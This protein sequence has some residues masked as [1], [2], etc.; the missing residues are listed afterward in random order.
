MSL[1]GD[2]SGVRQSE[3]ANRVRRAAE[4]ERR[5][6][7]GDHGRDQLGSR[8]AAV[9]SD[10]LRGCCCSCCEVERACCAVAHRQPITA[11]SRQMPYMEPQ[12][13]SAF[14]VT[15]HSPA[16]QQIRAV[17]GIV[18]AH[19][20][21]IERHIHSPRWRR[22]VCVFI[23]APPSDTSTESHQ[24][25]RSLQHRTPQPNSLPHPLHPWLLLASP[26]PRILPQLHPPL[27]APL[28]NPLDSPTAHSIRL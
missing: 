5:R 18:T 24:N 7:L 14:D 9:V 11:R 27:S 22:Y 23:S 6:R 26:R 25:P 2:A 15:A 17:A 1:L 12:T 19:L 16:Q 3:L 4:V 13:L 10:E 8:A 21:S 20:I 28:P